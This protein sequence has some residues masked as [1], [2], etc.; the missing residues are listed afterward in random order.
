MNGDQVRSKRPPFRSDEYHQQRYPDSDVCIVI[1]CLVVHA[2]DE[3]ALW[4]GFYLLKYG[5]SVAWTQAFFLAGAV[6]HGLF[7]AGVVHVMM[8]HTKNAS[9]FI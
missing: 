2:G 8:L 6:G 1:L 7:F 3:H 9:Y 5:W 4:R